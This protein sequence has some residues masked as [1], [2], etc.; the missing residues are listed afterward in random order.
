[1]D[2]FSQHLAQLKAHATRPEI[3]PMILMI[4]M[5]PGIIIF[6][7]AGAQMM[8]SMFGGLGVSMLLVAP[9]LTASAGPKANL[10]RAGL[11]AAALIAY[12]CGTHVA[13][14]Q[15]GYA[16][17]P[18]AAFDKLAGTVLLILGAT[19]AIIHSLWRALR[20]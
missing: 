4:G 15:L 19:I 20:K 16:G 12:A 18:A 17:T 13:I 1:M 8:T 11:V 10:R 6:A 9:L 2:R 14:H 5:F 3:A 7:L